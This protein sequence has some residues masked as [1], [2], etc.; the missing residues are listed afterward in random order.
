MEETYSKVKGVWKYLCRAVDKEG[1]TVHFVLTAQRDKDAALRFFFK[2]IKAS[3]V[4][5]KATMDKSGAN[6]AAMDEI[7]AQ[8]EIPIIE[9][10]SQIPE[11]Y[12]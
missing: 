4:R 12:R 11:Q 7:N 2:A 3:G 5:E 10:R 9:R 8:G 6:K 1:K